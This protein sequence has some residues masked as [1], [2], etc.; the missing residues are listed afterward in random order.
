MI[1]GNLVRTLRDAPPRF[2]RDAVCWFVRILIALAGLA[3]PK[4]ILRT[5][6]TNERWCSATASTGP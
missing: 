4:P 5:L 1:P 2:A 3:D 6:M